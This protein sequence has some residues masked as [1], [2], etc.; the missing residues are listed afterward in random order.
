VACRA[1]PAAQRG[2]YRRVPRDDWRLTLGACRFGALKGK[3]DE[4]GGVYSVV[5]RA[6]LVFSRDRGCPGAGPVRYR[7]AF[8]GLLLRLAPRGDDPCAGRGDDLGAHRWVKLFRGRETIVYDLSSHRGKF[9]ASGAVVDAGTSALSGA[10][11][12]LVGSH[13]TIVVA[14]KVAGGRPRSWKVA[15]ATGS[16]VQMTGG[17]AASAR[18]IGGLVHA[19]LTGAV[20]N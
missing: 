3:A 11:L 17:G 14:L 12:S 4:G 16:Y 19:T 8:D 2:V 5:G 10:R 15:S 7:F 6:E 1:L 18:V 13:G 20:A 9:R